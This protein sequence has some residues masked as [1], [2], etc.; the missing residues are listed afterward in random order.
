VDRPSHILWHRPS[1][2]LW[3]VHHTFCG[4]VHRTICGTVH[5]TFFGIVHYTICGPSLTHSVASVIA[6][7]SPTSSAH[8]LPICTPTVLQMQSSESTELQY[9]DRLLQLA[10]RVKIL[11]AFKPGEKQRVKE[12]NEILENIPNNTRHKTYKLFLYN[13]LRDAGPGPVALCAAALGQVRITK[14]KD[15]ARDK[16][17]EKI[18]GSR[19][20]SINHPVVCA[21]SVELGIPASVDGKLP[22]STSILSPLT[23]VELSPLSL[24]SPAIQPDDIQIR[25]QHGPSQDAQRPAKRRQ[26]SGNCTIQPS[27]LANRLISERPSSERNE[28]QEDVVEH[29]PLQGL[30]NVFASDMCDAIRRIHSQNDAA[31]IPKAAVMMQFPKFSLFDCVM[32]LEVYEMEVERLVKD[33]F[34]IE[35]V[36]VMGIRHLILGNGVKLTSNTSNP[37]FTLKGVRDEAILHVLGREIYE[38]IMASRMR[39]R[40]LEEDIDCATEC[41][42]MIFTSKCGEA[43]YINVCLEL[44]GGLR[45]RDKLRSGK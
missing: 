41:V 32:M 44:E 24:L 43:A 20:S 14:L 7:R 16:L 30:A 37:E 21:L 38:A 42:S 39:K 13:V 35:V 36:S 4:I 10:E 31:I 6:R 22:T 28:A 29:V 18:K 8:P 12:T 25:S 3:T 27:D 40:E 15:S 11:G 2:H 26:M 5:Y 23:V 17:R 1:H 34:G 19:S 9:F 33:L 45:I